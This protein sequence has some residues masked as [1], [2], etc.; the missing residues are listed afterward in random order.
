MEPVEP[1]KLV[2]D[3]INFMQ[4]FNN[5]PNC[6]A[7][8]THYVSWRSATPNILRGH[9]VIS[10]RKVL[11]SGEYTR[12]VTPAPAASACSYIIQQ[13]PPLRRLPLLHA[14]APNLKHRLK[15]RSRSE[16]YRQNS[17]SAKIQDG[18]GP[19]FEIS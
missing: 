11:S 18:G 15:M 3:G 6:I 4:M 14:F 1:I 5:R 8:S 10:R 16:I 19:H 12:S 17:H 2:V 7:K 13:H 9:D